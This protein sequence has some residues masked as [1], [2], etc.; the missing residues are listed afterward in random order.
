MGWVVGSVANPTY[1]PTQAM[2]FLNLQ[3][4][5]CSTHEQHS[6]AHLMQRTMGRGSFSTGSSMATISGRKGASPVAQPWLTAPNARMAALYGV[7]VV[8]VRK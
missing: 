8:D 6:S 1:L 3:P 4:I 2:H 7:C 5:K